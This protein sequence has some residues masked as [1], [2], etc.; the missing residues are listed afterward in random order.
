M[1]HNL[2]RQPVYLGDSV[3]AAFDGWHVVLTT[4]NGTGPTNTICLEP[5][6]IH[7]LIAYI[8]TLKEVQERAS[9][10]ATPT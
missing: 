5:A 1:T 8:D 4:D 7:G 6:V 9:T 10:G 3:Y 2:W